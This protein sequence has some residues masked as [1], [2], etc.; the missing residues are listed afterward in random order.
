MSRQSTEQFMLG[1]QAYP[2]ECPTS[3]ARKGIASK[4]SSRKVVKHMYGT[5][6]YNLQMN[7][8]CMERK[9]TAKDGVKDTSMKWGFFFFYSHIIYILLELMRHDNKIQ[10]AF[11]A[12]SLQ[13]T[14]CK[15]HWS[16]TLKNETGILLEHTLKHVLAPEDNLKEKSSSKQQEPNTH[17]LL[18]LTKDIYTAT[19]LHWED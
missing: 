14:L 13:S 7:L 15:R 17:H 8:M 5:M 3:Q 12:E 9:I 19:L 11:L 6:L 2:S 4:V 16:L 1:I 10:V 18:A